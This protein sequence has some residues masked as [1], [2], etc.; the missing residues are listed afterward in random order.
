MSLGSQMESGPRKL[1]P[2]IN[3]LNLPRRMITYNWDSK[4]LL[5]I[6]YSGIVSGD[7]LIQSAL[8]NAG[9]ER[10]DDTHFVL[11][12]WTQY[13][14]TKIDQDD[15]KA[16]VAIMKSV[17]RITPNAK[18]ATV[19]RPDSTGNA[20]AAF[21]KMIGDEL[22]WEIEIFHSYE[23]AFNW[24]GIAMPDDINLHRPTEI[25]QRPIIPTHAFM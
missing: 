22:P 9:D 25:I 5:H 7:E 18:N 24:F 10:F 16:L 14:Y 13:R 1:P 20:L 17:C 12:D 3:F 2:T 11:G 4:E 6:F 8:D 19:I 15:V 21:Y 23:D